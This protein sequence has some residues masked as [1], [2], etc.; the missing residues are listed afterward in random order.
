MNQPKVY[1]W[2]VITDYPCSMFTVGEIVKR[3]E[4]GVTYGIK[5]GDVSEKIYM[6]NYPLLFKRL[7]YEPA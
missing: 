1:R 6:I 7:E 4:S 3:Y 2:E 5:I